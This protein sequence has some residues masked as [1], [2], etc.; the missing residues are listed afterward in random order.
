M[1]SFLRTNLLSQSGNN[2]WKRTSLWTSRYSQVSHFYSKNLSH[3]TTNP[4]PFCFQHFSR[5]RIFG[6]VLNK[7]LPALT[8]QKNYRFLSTS[9]RQQQQ[10]NNENNENDF[11]NNLLKVFLG[12]TFF[13]FGT[14]LL[15]RSLEASMEQ[16][17]ISWSEFVEKYLVTGEVKRLDIT[18]QHTVLVQLHHG[19]VVDGNRENFVRIGNIK[20]TAEIE[21]MLRRE[22][23]RLN[24]DPVDG[25]HVQPLPPPRKYTFMDLM[26]F[27][28]LGLMLVP[29]LFGRKMMSENSIQ[30]MMKTVMGQSGTDSLAKPTGIYFKDV[31]G[32]KEAKQEVMEFVDFLKRP[33]KYK[34]L[35]AKMPKGCLLTGPP[36]VGKTLLAKAVASESG[37][38]FIPKSGSDF[39]ELIGGLGAKRVRQLFENARKMA[40]CIVYI[41]EL[42]AIGG[43]RKDSNSYQ[44]SSEKDRTLNQILVEMDGMLS[45]QHDVLVL[46]STNRPDVL[47]KAIT[48]PGRF[49]RHIYIDLPTKIERKQIL[50]RHLATITLE[51]QPK[52]YS[53]Q[54]ATVTPGMSGADLA[55]LCNL[56]AIQAATEGDKVVKEKH[57]DYAVERVIA[58]APKSST[59][60]SP[61][62]RKIVA[63]HESGH[64]LMGW[65]LEHT[66]ALSKV[67]I[68]P[69]TNAALGF[70]RTLPTERHLHTPEQI[71]D[72]MC[73]ALGGRAAEEIVFGNVTQGAQDDLT[74]VTDMAY[75]HV[76]T[77]G[78][79]PVVGPLSFTEDGDHS[80][81]PYS[82]RLATTMDR[83]VNKLIKSAYERAKKVLQQN[84]ELLDTLTSALFER[85]SL[86]FDDVVMLIGA[87]AYGNKEQIQTVPF[88]PF[89]S[90]TQ[91]TELETE[92]EET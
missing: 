92:K 9:A 84:R 34:T 51:N 48:R 19:A 67:S 33:D 81:R 45:A 16:Q 47:D 85:E 91:E 89:A 68:I 17:K 10:S 46:A 44:D 15:I 71:L 49:D 70:S 58:G 78:F 38:P 30:K 42:D 65:L 27:A 12:T 6:L 22:E 73:M 76:K 13:A 90:D 43:Q 7:N 61:E 86:N 77:F 18:S 75:A 37:V 88:G 53:E 21:G 5:D 1:T 50:E 39:V 52:E 20:N 72:N 56:A 24:I 3:I 26:F 64:A 55:N 28:M 62:E 63:V 35:G 32:M 40:P 82:E 60:V 14:I 36:G 11:M 57:L 87:P 66:S 59:A 83:E 41:D 23:R 4:P 31:A 69:R 80:L 25:I 2:F 79:N 8:L 54:L 29:L 74:K